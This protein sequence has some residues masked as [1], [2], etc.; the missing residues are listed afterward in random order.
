MESMSPPKR[1]DFYSHVLSSVGKVTMEQVAEALKNARQTIGVAESM[2]GGLISA[3]LTSIPGSSDYF[4]GG[5]VCYSNLMKV[6]EVGVP[7][8]LI[9]EHGVVSREV[10]QAMAEGIRK[11]LKTDIGLSATG[12]ASSEGVTYVGIA[13]RQGIRSEELKL[14]GNRDEIREK[15][16]QAAVGIVWMTLEEII[17]KE[18]E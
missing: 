14:Q 1:D 12:I 17:P 5:I 15:A 4:A 2:T 3:M 6:R 9:A 18:G 16:A 11:R 8:G 13:T 10:A 7:A